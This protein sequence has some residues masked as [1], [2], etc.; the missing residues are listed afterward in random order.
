MVEAGAEWVGCVGAV[1]EVVEGGGV[2]TAV[3]DDLGSDISWEA[4]LC[5]SENNV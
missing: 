5:N 2:S 4:C 1:V 3:V